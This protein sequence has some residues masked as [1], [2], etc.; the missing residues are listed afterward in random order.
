MAQAPRT[1]GR[2]CYSFS[3]R[4]RQSGIPKVQWNAIPND[5]GH[6]QLPIKAPRLGLRIHVWVPVYFRKIATST[7]GI[8][9][10]FS[11]SLGLLPSYTNGV[12]KC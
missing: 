5:L 8:G 7:A 2:S 10:R 4:F 11:T 12:T 6:E 1:S 3:S 9:H